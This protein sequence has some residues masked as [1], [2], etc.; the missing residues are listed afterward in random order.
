MV[1]SIA[2]VSFS[3]SGGA[4]SVARILSEGQRDQGRD[5]SLHTVITSNLRA[6]P[7]SAP[8]HTLSAATDDFLVRNPD[9]DSPISLFRDERTGGLQRTI[10]NPDII[11]LHGINGALSLGDV[12]T[13]WPTTRVVWTLHD[14]NPFTGACHY[15]LECQGYEGAC[16]SCP[17]V[18]PGWQ[19]KVMINLERKRAELSQIKHLK[20]VAPST[21]LAHQA[22]RSSAMRGFDIEVIPNPVNPQFTAEEP[23]TD[24][25]R[26]KTLRIVVIA[27]NLM[28]PVKDVATAVDAFTRAG[29]ASSGAELVLVGKGGEG[30]SGAGIRAAGAL[31]SLDLRQLL[32]Q[33]DV[34][35]LSSRAENAPLVIAEAASAGVLPIVRAVGGMPEMV[36]LLGHGHTFVASADLETLLIKE[37]KTTPAARLKRRTALRS[38]AQAVWGIDSVIALYD[39][40]YGS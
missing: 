10:G 35:V 11:H 40:V 9:F 19:N 24:S 17:A 15:S 27:Q 34:L 12:A 8:L 37:S 33:C 39:K 3:S 5:S 30:Y 21:W 16:H 13:T 31:P 1:S 36:A 23:G 6:A 2:H 4:G 29:L 20:I 22:S 18:R 14:M 25:E 28:D 26:D 38:K 7:L 32:S